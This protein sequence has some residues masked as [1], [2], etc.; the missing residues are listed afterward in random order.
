MTRLLIMKHINTQKLYNYWKEQ[1]QGDLVPLRYDI[2][3]AKIAAHLPDI[4]LIDKLEENKTISLAGSRMCSLFDRELKGEMFPTLFAAEDQNTPIAVCNTVANESVPAIFGILAHTKDATLSIETLMLPLRG[5]NN[6]IDSLLCMLSPMS[7]PSW[8]GH[9]AV[10]GLEILSFR[11][12][13]PETNPLS[14][15]HKITKYSQAGM[16]VSQGEHQQSTKP[17]RNF[18][19]IQGGLS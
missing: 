1:C 6:K 14:D 17:K 15:L 12:I 2:E 10:I 9:K 19:V 13:W 5:E 11:I 16:Y 4:F 8:I 18:T 7:T 3:P